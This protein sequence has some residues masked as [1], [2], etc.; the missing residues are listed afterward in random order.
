MAAP[1]QGQDPLANSSETH[2]ALDANLSRDFDRF[3]DAE[4]VVVRA[5]FERV[6]KR[7]GWI[8]AA[9]RSTAMEFRYTVPPERDR[10]GR[11]VEKKRIGHAGY[12]ES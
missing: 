12:Q 6:R 3:I 4:L 1:Y 7:H 11:A 2:A 10:F 5:G 8:I 9:V